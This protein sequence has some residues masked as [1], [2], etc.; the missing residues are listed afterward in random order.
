MQKEAV[1]LRKNSGHT[2][3]EL[4]YGMVVIIYTLGTLLLV[5]NFF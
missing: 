3:K 1:N 5:V 4:N 2:E